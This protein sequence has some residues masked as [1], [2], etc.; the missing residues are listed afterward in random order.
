[1]QWHS[2]G[3]TFAHFT[4]FCL[5][6]KTVFLDRYNCN[7]IAIY[8]TIHVHSYSIIAR[9]GHQQPF[10]NP[11]TLYLFVSFSS[12]T[13]DNQLTVSKI[14]KYTRIMNLCTDIW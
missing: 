6:I 3:V 9:L 13:T 7:Y 14:I 12:T 5:P 10:K 4:F 1:M 8:L 2:Q 11:D